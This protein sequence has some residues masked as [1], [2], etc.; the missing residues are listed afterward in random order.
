MNGAQSLFKALVDA[1]TASA[2]S[3]P[4][5]VALCASFAQWDTT[6]ARSVN[7]DAGRQREALMIGKFLAAV[8]SQGLIELI[9]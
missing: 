9:G 4:S 7:V 3:S 5:S 6:R 2:P 8:P 1:G